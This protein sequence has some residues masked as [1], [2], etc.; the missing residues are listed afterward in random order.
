M[1]V[2]NRSPQVEKKPETSRYSVN[3][4]LEDVH[5]SIALFLSP[6]LSLAFFLFLPLFSSLSQHLFLS[7]F[8]LY[9]LVL[10]AIT[11]K[12]RYCSSCDLDK[13][14]ISPFSAWV[15]ANLFAYL[16]A[17]L[18]GARVT[19]FSLISRACEVNERARKSFCAP[20]LSSARVCELPRSKP[21]LWPLVTPEGRLLQKFNGGKRPNFC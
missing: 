8:T 16:E 7:F 4:L 2:F 19:H 21:T 6:F 12:S 3:I 13:S 10:K 15:Q 9:S 17:A 1:Q 18:F 14:P 11:F 5:P 20:S